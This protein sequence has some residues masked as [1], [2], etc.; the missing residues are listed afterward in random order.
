MRALHLSLLLAGLLGLAAHASR[1]A[2]PRLDPQSVDRVAFH[3]GKLLAATGGKLV[4]PDVEIVFP[5]EIKIA[6]NA[7][8]TVQGGKARRFKEGQSLDRAGLLQNADGS[9]EP[10]VDHLTLRKGRAELVKD[11]ERSPLTQDYVFPDGSKVSPDG[12]IRGRDGRLSRLLDGQIRKLD[13]DALAAT[14]TVSLL[15]GKVVLFKDGSRME[16]RPGQTITMS[17]GTKV[18]SDGALLKFDGSRLKLAE[19]QTLRLDGARS[20]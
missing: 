15:K 11:G 7:T 3:E 19:G 4:E 17:D 14:D 18:F 8:F 9:L 13:G 5:G 6:T 12:T 1:A 10:V 16:L 20:K 2:E